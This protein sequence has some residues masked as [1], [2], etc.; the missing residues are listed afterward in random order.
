MRI[1]KGMKK[2]MIFLLIVNIIFAMIDCAYAYDPYLPAHIDSEEGFAYIYSEPSCS[3]DYFVLYNGIK[4]WYNGDLYPNQDGWAHIE[5]AT[6][7]KIHVSGWINYNDLYI[8]P[9]SPLSHVSEEACLQKGVINSEAILMVDELQIVID[10]GLEVYIGGMN[11][12]KYYIYLG[13]TSSTGWIAKENVTLL[14]IIE[15]WDTEPSA[16]I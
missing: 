10:Q 7:G 8:K 1:V 6:N 14:D 16:I 3:S 2:C 12:N 5:L 15:P 4:V 9:G 11:D 13:G